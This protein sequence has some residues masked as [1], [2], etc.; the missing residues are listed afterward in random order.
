MRNEDH[1]VTFLFFS[2]SLKIYFVGGLS[3]KGTKCVLMGLE[4]G[5]PTSCNIFFPNSVYYY[6]KS[7]AISGQQLWLKSKG[8]KTLTH[9]SGATSPPPV[10]FILGVPSHVD[11]RGEV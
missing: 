11:G 6:N 9:N 5:T 3:F 1:L 7:I 2:R 8:A 10:A 4:K